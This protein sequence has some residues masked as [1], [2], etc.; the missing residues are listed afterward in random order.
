MISLLALL[1]GKQKTTDFSAISKK[2]GKLVYF[3][4]KENMD[5]AVQ[6]GTHDKPKIKGKDV[7]VSKS[8]DL[9]KGDY[10]KERGG[11]IDKG[12]E[13]SEELVN[14]ITKPKG[15]NIVV[16]LNRK[17]KNG[18]IVPDKEFRQTDITSELIK[19]TLE[20]SGI[21]INLVNSFGAE[22]KIKDDV[23]RKQPLHSFIMDLVLKNVEAKQYAPGGPAEDEY[24][25]NIYT[26]SAND[27]AKRI[28]K[29]ITPKDTKP[30]QADTKDKIQ[31]K[32]EEVSQ[33][34]N[35][36]GSMK[37]N[38]G[39]WGYQPTE[40]DILK[41]AN[42]YGV[43]VNR[44]LSNPERFIE[45]T[46]S[47]LEKGQN[48]KDYVLQKL[49]HTA[50]FVND[51]DFLDSAYN[52]SELQLAFPL[53]YKGLSDSEWKQKIA[54]EDNNPT[55]VD[56]GL[57]KFTKDE[58]LSSTDVNKLDEQ[59]RKAQ[60]NWVAQKNKD[61]NY[62]G[63]M[64]AYQQMISKSALNEIDNML[65]SDPPP[66][67]KAKALYRGMAMKPADLRKLLKTFSEGNEI[68]LP[69]SSFS[70]DPSVAAGFSN[71]VNNDNATIDKSNNQSVLIKVVNSN[72]TF[73]GF[74]MNS[75]IGTADDSKMQENFGNWEYQ[76]EVLLPS[77]NKYKVVKT[78]SKKMDGGRSVTI[79]T[80][81]LIGTKNEQI[82]LKEL[83]E[84]EEMDFLKK[85][86]QYPNRLSLLYKKE[87]N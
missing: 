47:E 51:K 52:L 62:V 69:I 31:Y 57:R 27:I 23:G 59:N 43:D 75:N 53:K 82:K 5:A 13:P 38:G 79:I 61:S 87:E 70:I 24:Y 63:T 30:K 81:E 7:K 18:K 35:V 20:D 50:T 1:E 15:G 11:T 71:N 83:I 33:I 58:K 60:K 78:E 25:F 3:D 17:N 64:M 6:S 55:T 72:N 26:N 48:P 4:S 37:D 46:G 65:K 67:I 21:D 10:E 54:E 14:A 45:I 42:R 77:N 41:I 9:F 28:K 2:T 34:T 85:H 76:Q 12:N 19:K 8:S 56:S 39:L 29:S 84:S 32:V 40:K 16:R 66:P 73:N 22:T 74:S 44:I 68:E 36:L 80:L 49:G 86:L